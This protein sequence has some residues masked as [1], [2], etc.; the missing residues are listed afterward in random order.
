MPI[1]NH[2]IATYSV[3]LVSRA[4]DTAVPVAVI[5][6]RT[7]GTP[8]HDVYLRYYAGSQRPPNRKVVTGETIMYMV[9]CRY[10]QLAPAV[11]LLRNEKPMFFK[12]DEDAAAAHLATSDEPVGEGETDADFIRFDPA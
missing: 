3:S 4:D 5:H 9:S 11:D 6:A 10:D 7:D 2:E 1:D 8:S 12:Y